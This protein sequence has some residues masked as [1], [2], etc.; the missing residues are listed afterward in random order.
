V[1][2]PVTKPGDETF[3]S[4]WSRRK[5]AA[6]RDTAAPAAA[7]ASAE[8][9]VPAVAT[10][11]ASPAAAVAETPLPP[12]ESL[13]F[14]SDFAPFLRPGVAPDVRQS[15]LRTL[16]RD[17][18][19]NVMDGL[20]VYI[21]DYTKPAPLAAATVAGMAQARYIFAPPQTRVNAAGVVEDVPAMTEA[22]T[23][24]PRADETPGAGA[25]GGNGE[26]ADPAADA[27]PDEP[28]DA[29]AIDDTETLADPPG[30]AASAPAAAA[31]SAEV[32]TA[33]SPPPARAAGDCL[34]DTA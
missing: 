21:D 3:L 13:T 7:P 8:P 20:D 31:A 22:P 24:V 18:H 27:K 12:V 6:A 25:I 23:G 34:K 28:V 30:I 14:E 19:F 29:R 4:R 10:S 26:P 16:L 1:A 9:G 2:D 33:A 17:P 15:A 5:H 32:D 11:P